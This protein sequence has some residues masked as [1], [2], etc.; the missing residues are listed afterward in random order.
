MSISYRSIEY[1]DCPISQWHLNDWNSFIFSAA[2]TQYLLC[3]LILYF[4]P[5]KSRCTF[6][7]R[8]IDSYLLLTISNSLC[9]QSVFC[10]FSWKGDAGLK[11]CPKERFLSNVF[12][13]THLENNIIICL[14]FQVDRNQYSTLRRCYLAILSSPLFCAWG[15]GFLWCFW[16]T[17]SFC[18]SLQGTS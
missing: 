1:F 5:P 11:C 2:Y 7:Y 4:Q 18:F 9:F 17:V 8:Q 13:W 12:F 14:E 16:K 15:V 3:H 10:F 6:F